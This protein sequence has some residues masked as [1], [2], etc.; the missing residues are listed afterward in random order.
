MIYVLRGQCIV[1]NWVVLVDWIEPMG[2]VCSEFLKRWLLPVSIYHLLFAFGSSLYVTSALD[3]YFGCQVVVSSVKLTVFNVQKPTHI[4]WD[5]YKQKLGPSIVNI[6]EQSVNCKFL[7]YFWM[8]PFQT[9]SLCKPRL[10]SNFESILIF[11]YMNSDVNLHANLIVMVLLWHCSPWKGGAG[12]Q[13]WRHCRLS[14][15]ASSV[16]KS[17]TS[18]GQHQCKEKCQKPVDF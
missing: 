18:P 8:Q 1:F 2:E 5:F 13:G 14:G 10:F 4:N 17:F 3:G 11:G 15:Q 7:E 16:G 12:I 6:F 9:W